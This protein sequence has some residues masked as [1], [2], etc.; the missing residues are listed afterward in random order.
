MRHQGASILLYNQQH[1]VLLVLRDN[2][3]FIAC[4]NTWDAPG[5]HLDAHETP[6]HCIVREMME[7]MELDVSTCSHFKSYEFSN[8]TEHIFTMQTD[9]LNTATTPLHEGQMIRWFT[10]ADAL[11][12]SLASDMEVVLHDV[13]IW[14]EQQN[15]GTEDCG[16][17]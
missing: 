17:V 7:E 2:L 5:G 8:R 14:L 10:V 1:E 12:L 3:P 16:N 15:N 13:G 6:L 4:P 11:Q 9:V